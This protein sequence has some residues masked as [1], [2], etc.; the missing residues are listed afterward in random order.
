M[1]YKKLI[2]FM[3]SEPTFKMKKKTTI[4]F[5]VIAFIVAL[6]GLFL[7]RTFAEKINIGQY[8]LIVANADSCLASDV[9]FKPSDEL[10]ASC[11]LDEAGLKK[12]VFEKALKGYNKLKKEG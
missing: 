9:K 5:I 4:I 12:A 11:H 2:K 6:S 7:K 3:V 8:T 1:L 10:Y